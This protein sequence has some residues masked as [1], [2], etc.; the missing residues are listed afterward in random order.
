MCVC[1]CGESYIDI[2]VVV[3]CIGAL[4][5]YTLNSLHHEVVG[6]LNILSSNHRNLYNTTLQIIPTNTIY[7]MLQQNKLALFFVGLRLYLW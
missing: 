6:Y 4:I 5:F 3:C 2:V 7:L 1:V